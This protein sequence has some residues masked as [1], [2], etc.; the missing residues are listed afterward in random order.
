MSSHRRCDGLAK[1]KSKGSSKVRLAKGCIDSDRECCPWGGA[2]STLPPISTYAPLGVMPYSTPHFFPH[3]TGP[4]QLFSKCC[5][6]LWEPDPKGE[7]GS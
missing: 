1:Q 2:P 6:T 3:L 4:P 7:L 5:G